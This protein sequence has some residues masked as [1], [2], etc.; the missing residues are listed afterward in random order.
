MRFVTPNVTLERV[1]CKL[2][3]RRTS[4]SS[5]QVGSCVP[6]KRKIL[7]SDGTRISYLPRVLPKRISVPLGQST[8]T[9]RLNPVFLSGS[10]AKVSKARTLEGVGGGLGAGTKGKK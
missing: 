8:R 2:R 4:A 3:R 6:L 10:T 5:A 7:Q 1:D 9:L